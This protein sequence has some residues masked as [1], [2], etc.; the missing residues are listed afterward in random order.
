MNQVDDTWG[1]AGKKKKNTK[2]TGPRYTESHLDHAQQIALEPLAGLLCGLNIAVNA[3]HQSKLYASIERK[4]DMSTHTRLK[5]NAQTALTYKGEDKCTD[6]TFTKRLLE[7]AECNDLVQLDDMAY[8]L[9]RL[10]CRIGQLQVRARH[11]APLL[12]GT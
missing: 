10:Q 2:P 5:K 11:P 6:S 8:G 9:D 3:R 1:T 4:L 12:R 7:N